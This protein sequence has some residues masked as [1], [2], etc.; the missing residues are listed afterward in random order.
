[1]QLTRQSQSVRCI[2]GFQFRIKLMGC[3]EV[4]DVESPSIALKPMPERSKRAVGVHPLTEI[5]KNL[6]TCFRAVQCFQLLPFVRLSFQYEIEHR[7]RKNSPFTIEAV[8]I[9]GY[10]AIREQM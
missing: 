5:A 3:F 9:N 1:M 8:A 7:F 10:I 6:F 2:P 4:G